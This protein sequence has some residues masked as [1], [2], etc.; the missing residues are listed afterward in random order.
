MPSTQFCLRIPN[1]LHDKTMRPKTEVI[2][3]TCT[4]A[5]CWSYTDPNGCFPHGG[6]LAAGTVQPGNYGPYTP[7]S[8]GTVT[9]DAVAGPCPPSPPAHKRPIVATGHTITVSGGSATHDADR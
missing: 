7:V 6:F 2:Y 9:F 1:G 3:I 5:C 4:E 8:K